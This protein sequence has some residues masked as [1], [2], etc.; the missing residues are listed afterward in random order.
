MRRLFWYWAISAV[1][2]V[3]A[4]AVVRQVTLA[5]WYDAIWIAPILGLV[6]LG[7]GLVTN[8]F[9]FIFGLVNLLTL[10]LL[11]FVLSFVLYTLALYWL[12][13]QPDGP[14]ADY[15]MVQDV[16]GAMLLAALMGLFSMLLNMVLPG[17]KS[18]K[19]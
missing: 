19:R 5:H 4:V 3:L 9:T 7:V 8:I 1:A 15:L 17:R 12:G 10:G 13:R 11:G 18:R 2:L 16:W 6:S 14:L